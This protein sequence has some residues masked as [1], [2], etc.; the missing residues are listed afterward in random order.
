[1]SYGRNIKKT[2]SF[3]IKQKKSIG[4][5]HIESKSIKAESKKNAIE[6]LVEDYVKRGKSGVFNFF[7]VE[8]FSSNIR[9]IGRQKKIKLSKTEH[10]ALK[11]L[12]E[13]WEECP[14]PSLTLYSAHGLS[15]RSLYEHTRKPL[16]RSYGIKYW[17]KI[18]DKLERKGLVRKHPYQPTI[19]L[20]TEEGLSYRK[21]STYK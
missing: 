3:H 6:K 20:L 10:W 17:T 1:M 9:E 15:G 5:V 13:F 18:L 8:T 16:K 21:K 4:G 7:E 11:K 2:Y 12:K 19:Y 14:G